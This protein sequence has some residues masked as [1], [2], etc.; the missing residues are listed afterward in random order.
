MTGVFYR[1]SHWIIKYRGGMGELDA[2]I[3]YICRGLLGIPNN[4]HIICILYVFVNPK[5]YIFEV[6]NCKRGER[7]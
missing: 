2:V 7:S 1:H 6:P 3:P 5:Y 4:V